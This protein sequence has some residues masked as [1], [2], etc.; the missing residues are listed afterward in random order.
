MQRYLFLKNFLINFFLFNN[1]KIPASPTIESIPAISSTGMPS[2]N[3]NFISNI[4]SA[5]TVSFGQVPTAPSLRSIDLPPAPDLKIPDVPT[6]TDITLP[7]PPL[8]TLPKF[9]AIAP[10]IEVPDLPTEFSFTD[11]PY[12]SDIR[13]LLFKKILNDIANGGT[14]LDVTVEEELYNRFL[15]RQQIEND[16]LYQEVQDQFSASGFFLTNWCVCS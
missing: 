10:D 14:G 13:V 5:P 9:D 2:K 16:R 8:I 6:I 4:P 7:S 12:N 3:F 15:T 11:D 1:L